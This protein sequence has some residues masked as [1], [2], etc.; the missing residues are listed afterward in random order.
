MLSKNKPKFIKVLFDRRKE[1]EIKNK[2]PGAKEKG[3]VDL[4]VSIEGKSIYIST[5][6]QVPK[7]DFNKNYSYSNWI[8]RSNVNADAYNKIIEG[9]ILEIKTIENDCIAKGIS[10]SKDMLLKKEAKQEIKGYNDFISF[11]KWHLQQTQNIK[12]NTRKQLNKVI[13]DL[14]GL[15]KEIPFS[16]VNYD[17]AKNYANELYRRGN[18]QNTVVKYIKKM[19]QFA[20]EAYRSGEIQETVLNSLKRFKIYEKEGTKVGLT[21]EDI[22]KL[23]N[24]VFAPSEKRLD[25]TRDLFLFAIYTG[26]RFSDIESLVYS[27]IIELE[28]H[29]TI[30]K[31]MQKTED[32][33]EI[34]ISSIVFEG[35]AALLIEKHRKEGETKCFHVNSNQVINRQLKQIAKIVNLTIDSSLV[36]FHTARHTFATIAINNGIN[37][38]TVQKLL[39]HSRIET[40]QIYAKKSY[41]GIIHELEKRQ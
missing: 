38:E 9:L 41:K 16:N 11:A 27:E 4:H 35:K 32:L 36:C 29:K 5:G 13:A 31:K 24:Y 26:L 30:R 3:K 8:K 20:N 10:L 19:K 23:E 40:T 14:Q 39:G 21:I 37:L 22:K 15:Y 1:T 2:S 6:L 28:G 7:K 33:V 17:L 12:A 18:G 34:P 25:N